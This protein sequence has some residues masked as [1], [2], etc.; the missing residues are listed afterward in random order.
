VRVARLADRLAQRHRED[1]YR[2]RLA[3]ILH[4]LARLYPTGRLVS[5]CERR[6]LPIDAF[7]RRNPIVLHAP[8]GAELARERFGIDDPCVLSAIR[9]HTLAEPEM[10][11]LDTLVYLADAL[12]PGRA[13]AERGALEALA[14]RDPEAAM[15]AVLRSSLRYLEARGLEAAPKTRAALAAFE[16]LERSPLSA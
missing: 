9:K 1:P 11:R 16:A 10:T 14:F 2:A 7:E 3:G 13:Y 8:L 12:E 6:G 15:A 5:D 4:D